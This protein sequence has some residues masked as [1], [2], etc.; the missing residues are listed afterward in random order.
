[1]K[2]FTEENPNFFGLG[3]SRRWEG[4]II[5]ILS[6]LAITLLCRGAGYTPFVLILFGVS[7]VLPAALIG[8]LVISKKTSQRTLGIS[9]LVIYVIVWL[10]LSIFL[11]ILKD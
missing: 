1:M 3:L 10:I 2:K 7:S 11:V 9:L 8:S 5:G 6:I 4:A